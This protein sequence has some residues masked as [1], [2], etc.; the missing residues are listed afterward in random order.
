[1]LGSEPFPH[2]LSLNVTHASL[3]FFPKT[4]RADFWRS[5]KP[6]LIDWSHP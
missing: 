2:F 4:S 6:H 1:M 5:V 3:P